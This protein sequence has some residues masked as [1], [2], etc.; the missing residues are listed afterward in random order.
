K[1]AIQQAGDNPRARALLYATAKQETIGAA[2]AEALQSLLQ[3]GLKRGEFLVTA[4]LVA[5]LLLELEPSPDL[6]W[7]APMAARALY[8]LDRPQEAAVWAQVGGQ[9]AQASLFLIARLAQ[10][11][12]GP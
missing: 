12:S 5:P 6:N 4:Q 11:D 1:T 8:A 9:P 7:F 10:G 2:R 3:A